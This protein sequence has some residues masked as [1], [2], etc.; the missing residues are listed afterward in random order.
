MASHSVTGIPL[1]YINNF[2]QI[3][4]STLFYS[5]SYGSNSRWMFLEPHGP[6]FESSGRKYIQIILLRSNTNDSRSRF[7]RADCNLQQCQPWCAAWSEFIST[8]CRMAVYGA[9]SRK[10]AFVWKK[11]KCKPDWDCKCESEWAGMSLIVF[12]SVCMSLYVRSIHRNW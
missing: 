10:T 4:C 1:P 2:I 6:L 8:V 5:M 11:P 7:H 12:V 9:P 3:W